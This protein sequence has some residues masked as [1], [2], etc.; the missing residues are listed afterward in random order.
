[1]MHN[2]LKLTLGTI[3]FIAVFSCKEQQKI[4]KQETVVATPKEMTAIPQS[5]LDNRVSNAKT[6][7]GASAAGQVIWNAMNAHGGLEQ[8][9]KNGA[10]AMRFNY[11]PLDGSTQRDSYQVV[12]PWS[13]RA[14]HTSTTDSTAT[15]GWTGA[16][17]WIMA[18][19]STAFAYDTKFWALTPLYL[20]GFPFVLDGTGVNLELLPQN[21]YKG[22][23][24]DVVKV[25]FDPGTGDAPDDYYIL[26]F[27]VD[28]HLL[29]ATRYIVSYPEYFKKGSHL[30]E[31]FMEVG[32]LVTIDGILLPRGL[33]THWT[34]NDQPGEYL[35]KIDITDIHF[36]GKMDKGFYA[37]P[38]GAKKL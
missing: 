29:T 16:A 17:A 23:K 24:N 26:Q 3:L 30:P 14:V 13:N 28:S 27:D 11:Q 12:D 31:K 21:T 4:E 36:K 22:R 32:E 35:T 5:W 34:K 7:L 20:M 25:T 10:L 37:M 15:Y 19:D 6:R 8:W 33:K 38:V 2:V 9:Y 1:M 18:K